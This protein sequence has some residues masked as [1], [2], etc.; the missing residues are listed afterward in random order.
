MF[1]NW[2]IKIIFLQLQYGLL[3][4]GNMFVNF[5]RILFQGCGC[6][7]FKFIVEFYVYLGFYFYV[8]GEEIRF[9]EVE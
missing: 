2:L 7:I 6:W 4:V 3:G 5:L 1:M 8:I 9:R